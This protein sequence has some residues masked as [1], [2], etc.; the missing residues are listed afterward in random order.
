MFS[1]GLV[2]FLL[3]LVVPVV[4]INFMSGRHTKDSSSA[5]KKVLSLGDY[6][7]Y[8]SLIGTAALY[9]WS[10]THGQP[11]NFFKQ[12]DANPHAPCFII[13]HK[14]AD[15]VREHPEIVPAS[16]I[17]TAQQKSDSDFDRL[18][19]Y[20]GSNYGQM[21]FLADRFC[22]YS[23]DRD[24]YLKFGEDVFLN[25]MSSDFGP[26]GVS[27]RETMP[28]GG[29]KKAGFISEFSETGYSLYAAATQFFTYL[30]AF[31]VI[32][33]I[34]TPFFVT[35]SAPSRSNGRPWA[36]ITLCTLY[37]AD[38]YSLFTTPGNAKHRVASGTTLWIISPDQ[39]DA[40]L[41][42]ADSS[43]YTRKI[44]LGTCLAAF[45]I[46]DY[47]TSSRQTDVQLLKQCIEAQSS[48]LAL[49]KNHTVLETSVLLSGKLR[50]RLVALWRREE[51]AREQLFAQQEL[52][53]KY[54]DVAAKTK[55]RQWTEHV[56]P[57]A[58]QSFGLPA[59]A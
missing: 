37:F 39:T 29:N 49:A 6:I 7:A 33:I 30:P 23:E 10:A 21:D 48:G 53:E 25:S 24:V 2:E 40:M 52:V 1:S 57:G 12:I 38:L 59:D 44:F 15:Y 41:F 14:L 32:G 5:K 26:R 56:L 16:G 34:T 27:A 20:R 9:V 8:A 36:V 47:L 19:Y 3:Y 50:D 58:L 18:A 22:Q 28:N 55:S 45:L 35:E 17:P 13:R 46:M 4:F 51:Q 31:A 42:Y 11:P 54:K 43:L